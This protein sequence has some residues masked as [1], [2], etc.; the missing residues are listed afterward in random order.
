MVGALV[1]ERVRHTFGHARHWWSA[2]SL[3]Q[4]FIFASSFTPLL[5][6]L[7]LGGWVAEAIEDGVVKSL[8]ASA[9]LYTDALIEPHVQELA[10]GEEISAENM[11]EIE[12]HVSPSLAGKH[13]LGLNI[14]KG[15]KIVFSL[16][17]ELI[18]KTF[19]S[20]PGR[21][22]AWSGEL[23]VEYNSLNEPEEMAQRASA[24][25]VLEFYVPVRKTGSHT[26][27]ALAETYEAP[28]ELDA[29]IRTARHQ[30]WLFVLMATSLMLALQ[31]V[32]V[33]HGSTIITLQRQNL[34]AKVDQLTQSLAENENLRVK[35]NQ[36]NQR[37]TETNERFLQRL[38]SDLH[39]GPVQL[40]GMSLL[41][42]DSLNTS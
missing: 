29:K 9:A 38:G 36:A 12:R 24:L 10:R 3:F 40:L 19:P 21:E 14:W 2:L 23:S 41:R 28:V 6:M 32:V 37:V 8:G 30:A 27:I 16:D 4:K 35:V 34:D 42:L 33:R 15:D 1:P 22:R 13:I 25:S 31:A 39:D 18:G 17:K 11:Q 20:S 5:G 7:F 26:V